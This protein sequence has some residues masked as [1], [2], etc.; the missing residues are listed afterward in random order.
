ME[1]AFTLIELIAVIVVLA[2][3]SAVA[4]PRYLDFSERASASSLASSVKRVSRAIEQYRIDNSGF[5]PGN[6][7]PQT[8]PVELGAYLDRQAFTTAL[9]YSLGFD[10]DSM[11]TSPS[12]TAVAWLD[13]IPTNWTVVGT[14]APAPSVQT[15]DSMMDDGSTSTGRLRFHAN[16]GV[17][18]GVVF[19]P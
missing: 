7:H 13:I 16:W 3:L 1:R 19:I 8:M 18:Y 17:R 9:P 10:W 14:A 6:A 11:S 12:S 5:L 4:I 15:L 2:I